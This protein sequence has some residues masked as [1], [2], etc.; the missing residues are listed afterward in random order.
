VRGFYE[1]WHYRGEVR[2]DDLVLIAEHDGAIIGVVRLALEHG[3]TVL[4]GMRVQAGFQRQG[5][6]TRLLVSASAELTGPCY[7]IPYAHLTGFYGQ[8]G[9]RV[10]DPA[11]APD[12]LAE[13][14][15][16]YRARADGHEYLVMYRQ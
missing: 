12:F 7:C 14:L 13:R 4:R 15:A 9:F 16:A 8:I 11:S 6:G 1:G 3:T 5:I 2:A 10:L